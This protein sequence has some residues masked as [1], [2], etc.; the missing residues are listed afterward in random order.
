MIMIAK[1]SGS[2]M[3]SPAAVE[4]GGE[5]RGGGRRLVKKEQIAIS[6]GLV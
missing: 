1:T 3:G 5:V 2:Q 4:D 6:V